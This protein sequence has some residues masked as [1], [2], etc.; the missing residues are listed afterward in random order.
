MSDSR[1]LWRTVGSDLVAAQTKR[2]NISDDYKAGYRAGVRRGCGFQDPTGGPG[3]FNLSGHP[4]VKDLRAYVAGHRDG[5]R[6]I[7]EKVEECGHD[8]ALGLV[9]SS[10]VTATNGLQPP[11][12]SNPPSINSP[13][14]AKLRQTTYFGMKVQSKRST[15]LSGRID[16]K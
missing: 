6:D 13:V 5:T 16:P 9:S 8:V 10:A 4:G 12:N 14:T 7:K 3:K 1:I 2:K 11:T 15:R